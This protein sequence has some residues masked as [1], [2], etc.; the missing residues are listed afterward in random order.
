MRL[1]YMDEA[2]TS[3]KEPI[4]V[5]IGIIVHPDTQYGVVRD[6]IYRLIGELVP[7]KYLPG[8][9]FHASDIVNRREYRDSWTTESRI[10]FLE[11]MMRIPQQ[12]GL[13][14][15][16]S[17]VRKAQVKGVVKI[18]LEPNQQ[19]H[20]QAFTQCLHAA[21]EHMN[22]R[23]WPTELAS[24]VAE[25]NTEMRRALRTYTD[26][27]KREAQAG[28][29]VQRQLFDAAGHVATIEATEDLKLTRIIDTTHFVAKHEAPLVQV[30][31]ACAFG[32]RRFLLGLKG[33]EQFAAAILG[34]SK[35]GMDTLGRIKASETA[36]TS[37]VIPIVPEHLIAPGTESTYQGV[38]KDLGGR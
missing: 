15:A 22:M 12:F 1:I 19:M 14:I 32:F 8:F 6:H 38:P 5:V 36:I 35:T 20:L 31:D 28:R 9:V 25:D 27:I 11:G 7:A 34:A 18:V 37:G 13:S 17:F 29:R 33:G 2:G 10:A 23:A 3:A 24:V 21:D 4:A 16:Y 26:L 30:A